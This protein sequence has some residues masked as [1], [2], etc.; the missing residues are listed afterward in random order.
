MIKVIRNRISLLSRG[1]F[2]NPS[3]NMLDIVLVLQE[4]VGS[5]WADVRDFAGV[6]ASTENAEV[7]E[8]VHG[9]SGILEE[10]F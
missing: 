1:C 10:L 9:E 8:L 5:D 3:E 7:D 6:V 2:T 4:I